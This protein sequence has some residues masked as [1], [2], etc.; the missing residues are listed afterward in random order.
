MLG[1][2]D[3]TNLGFGAT[4]PNGSETNKKQEEILQ[5]L[6]ELQL[7][8]EESPLYDNSELNTVRAALNMSTNGMGPPDISNM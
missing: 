6:F 8:S 3:P 1:Q 2:L 5:N 7:N 4:G